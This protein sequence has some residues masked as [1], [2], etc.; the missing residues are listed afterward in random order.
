MNIDEKFITRINQLITKGDDVRNH[1]IPSPPNVIGGG[2]IDYALFNE[3]KNNSEN[4]ISIACGKESHYFT[5]FIEQ[6]K[7]PWKSCVEN[8]VGILKAL[9]E[10]IETGFISNVKELVTAEV[11]VDFLD[12]AKHLLDAGYKDPSASLIGAVLED[13]LRKISLK[14]NVEVKDG[15]DIS[16]LN[17]KLGDKNIYNRLVQ[18]QIQAWK[19]VRDRADHGKFDEYKNEDVEAMLEGVQR[20]LSTHL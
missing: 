1:Y 5:N 17:T 14:N 2:H 3:W 18:Q 6:T 8:G 11:F 7:S 12:M 19:V 15:D 13:G 20:F 4:I 9:K 10:D 16:A